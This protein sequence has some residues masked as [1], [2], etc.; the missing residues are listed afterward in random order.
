MTFDFEDEENLVNQSLITLLSK[1]RSAAV[2]P[3]AFPVGDTW[4]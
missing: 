2:P 4:Q 1:W 3:K